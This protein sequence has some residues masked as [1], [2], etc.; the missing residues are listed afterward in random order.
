MSDFAITEVYEKLLLGV[1]QFHLMTAEQLCRLHYSPGSITTIKARLK[2]LVDNGYLLADKIPNKKPHSPFYY[3][4]G[5]S[6][7]RYLKEE[8]H[9]IPPSM[10][11][12]KEHDK[13]PTHIRHT[14]ELNDVIIAANLLPNPTL[15]VSIQSALQAI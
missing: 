5:V 8:G 13:Q 14:L 7:I 3:T 10:R 15:A 12:S 4:L 9:D 6:G 1:Y 11:A 2:T